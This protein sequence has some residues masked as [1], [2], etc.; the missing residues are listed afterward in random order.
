MTDLQLGSLIIGG[1]V[2][3]LVYAYNWWQEHRYR[4]Q[5]QKA[6]ARNHPDVLLETPKNMVRGGETRRMEPVIQ[7]RE[8]AASLSGAAVRSR[9]AEEKIEPMLFADEDSMDDFVDPEA[10]LAARKAVAEQPAPPAIEPQIEEP[11]A[12]E[13]P[14]EP[15][16]EPSAASLIHPALDFIAEIRAG[17]PI[18]AS[19]VP[20]FPGSK[21]M[22]TIGQGDEGRW[23]VVLSTSRS[24]YRELRV[25]QQL[26]DRQGALTQEHLN[27]F[28]MGVQQFADAIEAGATFPPRSA[29]LAAA[30]E[31][32]DFCAGVDVQIGLNVMAARSPFPM[33]KVSLLSES[34]GLVRGKDGNYQY[35]NDAGKL[36]F[37]LSN[38]DQTPF[39]AA[40]TG[41]TLLFDVPRAA[42]GLAA[43]DELVDF[44]VDL[45]SELGG[46]LADDNG[47][48]L[49]GTSLD[50]IRDQLAAI[51]ARMDERGIPAGS[52]EALR[53]FA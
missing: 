19:R 18:A 9:P 33:D 10:A 52:A 40:S 32:D 31:L 38:Q 7:P 23:E 42:G 43:F 12:E 11:Q 29:S 16:E 26:A 45:S 20:T 46:T 22:V 37:T 5:A 13:E 44:A 50:G 35:L 17:E 8:A 21:R 6:F 27:A 3:V 51:Y 1:A 41:L 53:L 4:Q 30:R 28:C 49:S 25:G 48:P 24:R 47:R 39:G 36:L 15:A 2:V 34:A 14:E